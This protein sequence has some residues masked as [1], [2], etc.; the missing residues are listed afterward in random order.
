MCKNLSG[1]SFNHPVGD[2]VMKLSLNDYHEVIDAYILRMTKHASVKSIY[3]VGKINTPGFSDV[4]LIIVT[5]TE[6]SIE[7]HRRIIDTS[8]KNGKYIFVH[9]P[10]FC[11]EFLFN[12]LQY[13]YTISEIKHLYGDKNEIENLP[14]ESPFNVL[15]INNWFISKI[16]RCFWRSYLTDVR[17]VRLIINHLYSFRHTVNLIRPFL[18]ISYEKWDSMID[19][20]SKIRNKWFESSPLEFSEVLHYLYEAIVLSYE[21]VFKWAE[22]I[23]SYFKLP[24]LGEWQE[25]IVYSGYNTNAV[26]QSNWSIQDSVQYTLEVYRKTN[27]LVINLPS[28]MAFPMVNYAMNE[29]SITGRY[30]RKN[31]FSNLMHYKTDRE[32]EVFA[33]H[34]GILDEYLKFQGQIG[35]P[36]AETIYTMGATA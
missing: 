22:Y 36:F 1:Y 18:G 13:W 12:K 19:D 28:C 16:P 35:N 20:I 17:D 2:A 31:L 25:E 32:Y 6:F 26:F 3:Q 14:Y 11:N 33:A 10:V 9:N 29:N 21:L 15:K 5:D 27:T 30:I 34:L 7:N 24:H 23:Q 4:D 8:D